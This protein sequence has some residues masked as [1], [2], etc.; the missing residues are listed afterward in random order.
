MIKSKEDYKAYLEADRIA[1]SA[2]ITTSFF[3]RAAMS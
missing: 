1:V 3:A 2:K